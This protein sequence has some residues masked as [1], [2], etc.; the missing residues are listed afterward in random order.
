MKDDLVE[1]NGVKGYWKL[2][3]PI[4]VTKNKD[5]TTTV[6]LQDATTI[7]HGVTIQMKDMKFAPS[8][9]ELAYETGFTQEEQARVAKEIQQL[10]AQIGG[11]SVCPEIAFR[12][13]ELN[14]Y[15]SSSND[16]QQ[17]VSGQ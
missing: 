13:D 12:T 3:V 7:H 16:G 9:N 15:Q 5:L 1:L 14:N 17:G 2:E 8:L 11:E 4:D 10:K 6:P